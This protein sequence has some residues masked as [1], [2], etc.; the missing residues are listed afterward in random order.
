MSPSA[1]QTA[2]TYHFRRHRADKRPEIVEKRR[3]VYR[4]A[5][6][7]FL[8]PEPAPEAIDGAGPADGVAGGLQRRAGRGGREE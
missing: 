4:D 1:P 3:R 6:S 8:P 7:G 2:L 5:L